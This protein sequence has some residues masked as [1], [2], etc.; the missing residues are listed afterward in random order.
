M[1]NEQKIAPSVVI[2]KLTPETP[3]RVAEEMLDAGTIT[4]KEYLTW[5]RGEHTYKAPP[6]GVSS[7]GV[8]SY[9][10]PG[11][12]RQWI[13][14]RA[15]LYVLER[16]CDFSAVMYDAMGADA[17][18]GS[19]THVIQPVIPSKGDPYV[20]HFVSGLKAGSKEDWLTMPSRIVKT[21]QLH[22]GDDAGDLDLDELELADIE[23]DPIEVTSGDRD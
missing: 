9:T 7:K 21:Y 15:L 1:S 8:I 2:G 18:D 20:G 12:R 17:V 19:I 13:D 10:V 5:Q 14:P 16:C 3:P 23:R 6:I 22:N 4:G 11:M